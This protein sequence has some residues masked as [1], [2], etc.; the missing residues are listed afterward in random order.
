MN[1]V[2]T[3]L[4][5]HSLVEASRPRDCIGHPR[6]TAPVCPKAPRPFPHHVFRGRPCEAPPPNPGLY[7]RPGGASHR[8]RLLLALL[9]PAPSRT[10]LRPR[11]S[12]RSQ[13]SQGTSRDLLPGSWEQ[14]GRQP[15]LQLGRA[16][17]WPQRDANSS[18][19]LTRSIRDIDLSASGT[20]LPLPTSPNSESLLGCS[21][22]RAPVTRCTRAARRR[23]QQLPA[24]STHAMEVPN[25][26]RGLQRWDPKTNK[27]RWQGPTRELRSPPPQL[28][29]PS[30]SLDPPSSAGQKRASKHINS[31][32]H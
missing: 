10:M 15:P 18:R 2:F 3:A 4:S 8:C 17:S 22:G 24:F 14:R 29:R 16:A 6:I 11:L 1:R 19:T 26:L 27:Y 25:T 13:T 30:L 7:G 28:S 31:Q 5:P 23:G 32:V 21:E 12:L 20:S 9:R